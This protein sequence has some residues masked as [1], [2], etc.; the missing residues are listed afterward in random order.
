MV[1]LYTS[2]EDLIS[3][4]DRRC[5]DDSED[6]SLTYVGALL[7]HEMCNFLITSRQDRLQRGYIALTQA[8][9]WAHD[10]LTQLDIE[11]AEDMLKKVRDINSKAFR[12]IY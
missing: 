12:A 9:P 2:L 8:L 3:E 10:K 11:D 4:N 5:E 1:A 7:L 6:T